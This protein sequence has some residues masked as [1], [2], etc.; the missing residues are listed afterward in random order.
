MGLFENALIGKKDQN[1]EELRNGDFIKIIVC[2]KGINKGKRCS[3]K[4]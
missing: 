2:K 4:K 3:F 1:G